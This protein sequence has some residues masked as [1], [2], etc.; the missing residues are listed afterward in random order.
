MTHQLGHGRGPI[1][2]SSLVGLVYGPLHELCDGPRV[3]KANVIPHCVLGSTR[4]GQQSHPRSGGGSVVQNLRPDGSVLLL[5]DILR[6]V[7]G[8]TT[9]DGVRGPPCW[10]GMNHEQVDGP[11]F[12]LWFVN[13]SIVHPISCCTVCWVPEVLHVASIWSD[14]HLDKATVLQFPIGLEI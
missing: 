7:W 1:P 14:H 8:S 4:L 9:C 12:L 2:P 3:V 11:W 6:I 5:R 13:P 10:I